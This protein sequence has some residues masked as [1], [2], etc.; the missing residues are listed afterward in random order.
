M[1]VSSLRAATLLRKTSISASPRAPHA[2]GGKGRLAAARAAGEGVAAEELDPP[3]RVVLLPDETLR[4]LGP[5]LVRAG[6]AALRLLLPF[7][8]DPCG[9][10]PCPDRRDV[11]IVI[12]LQPEVVE[13]PL[14]PAG[15]EGEIDGG[16]IDKPLQVVGSMPKRAV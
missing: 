5:V 12:K 9:F 4:V 11:P 14:R 7:A 10:E 2:V 8:L 13:P 3:R 6:V 16:V 1:R 15:G